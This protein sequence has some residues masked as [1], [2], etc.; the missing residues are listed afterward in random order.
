M[1]IIDVTYVRMDIIYIS[2]DI[3]ALYHNFVKKLIL[4]EF[5]GNAKIIMIFLIM[6]V[7]KE[8]FSFALKLIKDF[9]RYVLMDSINGMDYAIFKFPNV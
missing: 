9:V 8:K 1:E 2:K 6:L 5:V 4:Q 7:F 3:V